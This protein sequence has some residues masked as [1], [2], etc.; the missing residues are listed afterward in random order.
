LIEPGTIVAER[1]EVVC[2]IGEGGMGEVHEARHVDIGKRVAIKFLSRDFTDDEQTMKR[3]HQ[4]AKIAGNLG[5]ENIC[6][7]L[8][9]GKTADGQP[10][11]VMELL[12]GENLADAIRAE[13]SLPTPRA[14]AILYQVLGAIEEAHAHGILHRDLKPENVFLARKK[15]GEVVKLL[16]FGISKIVD[17]GGERMSLTKTGAMVG[18]PYYMSPEHVRGLKDVDHRTDIYSCGVMLYEMV[19]GRRPFDGTSFNEVMFKIVEEPFPTPEEE[20]PQPVL[21]AIRKAMERKPED[22]FQNAP[23]FRERVADILGTALGDLIPPGTATLE[24]RRSNLERGKWK[25]ISAFVLA[26][27]IAVLLIATV[28]LVVMRSRTAATPEG[29]AGFFPIPDDDKWGFVDE[30][31][32]LAIPAIYD[33]VGNFS[34]GYVKA[35]AGEKWGYVDAGGMMVI[36]PAFEKADD[37]HEGLAAVMLDGRWGFVDRRGTVAIAAIFDEAGDFSGG[38]AAIRSGEKWGY[39]DASGK[40]V[41]SPQFTAA[42]QFNEERAA[43]ATAGGWGHVDPSGEVVVA[44]RYDFAGPFSEGLARMKVCSQDSTE[45]CK[46]GYV[47]TA[48]KEVIEPGFDWA[49][50]FSEGLALVMADGRWGYVGRKGHFA[51]QPTYA[52]AASFSGGLARVKMGGRWGFIDPAGGWVMKPRYYLVGDF[53]GV[54]AAATYVT[55]IPR[56]QDTTMETDT[57]YVDRTGAFIWNPPAKDLSDEVPPGNRKMWN[58]DFLTGKIRVIGS[59]DPTTYELKFRQEEGTFTTVPLDL[60]H[61]LELGSI[62]TIYPAES[63]T[64]VLSDNILALTLGW[65]AIVHGETSLLKT[66]VQG[67]EVITNVS[68]LPLTEDA[69][70]KNLMGWALGKRRVYLMTRTGKL[71]YKDLEDIYGGLMEHILDREPSP[72]CTIHYSGGF[73][74]LFEPGTTYMVFKD[75]AEMIETFERELGFTANTAP[76]VTDGPEG[77][78][79]RFGDQEL[80]IDPAQIATWWESRH[81]E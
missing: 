7:V 15:Q 70:G 54:L 74:F 42:G 20:V 26:P 4:E 46:W 45:F 55:K 75:D 30:K 39:V 56:G 2:R 36:P 62:K 77:L 35:L 48:G 60:P 79:V 14:L 76:E 8:D 37:F 61:P 11:I 28:A 16:D 18:T 6:E 19:T 41:V 40:V 63:Y 27:I 66:R 43:V 9:Y 67:K 51:I 31:G 47:D 49:Y 1:Y 52:N 33:N 81:V 58:F 12:E 73:V 32:V 50:D 13:G 44:A 64:L 10:F 72:H 78:V 5:H 23:E 65:A 24:N 68:A 69:R 80:E 59:F 57:G 53:K 21:E 22:R 29:T 38:R 71:R 34:E 17:P 3:F 25:R